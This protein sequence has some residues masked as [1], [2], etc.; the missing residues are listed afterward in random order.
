MIGSAVAEDSLEDNA[1]LLYHNVNLSKERSRTNKVSRNNTESVESQ[2]QIRTEFSPS[3]SKGSIESSSHELGHKKIVKFPKGVKAL[4]TN[5]NQD[6]NMQKKH[7]T[8]R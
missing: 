6:F 3:F 1:K 7:Q 5:Y 8:L 4:F 2:N